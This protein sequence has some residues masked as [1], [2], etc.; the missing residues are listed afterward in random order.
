LLQP[1][2][3]YGYET[4]PL[5]LREEH[6][7]TVFEKRVLRRIIGPK[8][9]KIKGEWRRLHNEEFNDLYSPN[10]IQEIKS[11]RVRLVGNVARMGVI[12]GV[13]RNLVGKHEEKRPLGRPAHRWEDSVKM[14]FKK[15]DGGHGL[16]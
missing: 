4:W 6:R 8:R 5:T 1:V 12:R 15:W 11:R 9:N 7:L 13:Q 10:I 3:L 16:D 2:F 14:V